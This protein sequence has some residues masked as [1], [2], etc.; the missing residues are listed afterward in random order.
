[1]LPLWL[2][3]TLRSFEEFLLSMIAISERYKGVK[4]ILVK[5]TNWVGDTIIAFPAVH[6]L[7]GLFPQ[8]H[9]SVL[10]KAY[11]AELWRAN[12]D[13]DEVIP[14]D[15]PTGAR[16]IFGELGIA[17]LIRDKTIDLAIILPR[18]FSSAWMVFLGGVPNRIGYKSGGRD[19]L[20]TEGVDCKTEL[21]SRHRM[22]YYLKLVECLGRG[23][24]LSLPSLSLNGEIDKWA[25]NFLLLNG[26]K[27]KVVIGFNPG[28]T[29]GEAK[30]WPPERF[31]ELGRRLREDYGA[32][33]LIFGSS[34]LKEKDLNATIAEGIGEGCLNL[35]GQTSLLEL[36]SLLRQCHL[37]VTNDTG[38]MHV[39]AAAGTRVVAIFGPTDPRTTSPLGEGHVIIRQ[40]VSCSPCL[41]RVC[42]E[43]HRCMD[44]IGVAKVYKT[45][46]AHLNS[47]TAS[48]KG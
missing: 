41:K 15:M 30:C 37:L 32:Y 38:T 19:W 27:G 44:L 36:T 17:R 13:I 1:M 48:V 35:S 28:A 3:N 25:N 22:Y 16:R 43:D 2:T 39:A 4:K 31:V 21:L 33:I 24:S 10:A 20:L 11:L 34:R 46:S 8:V 14:Y 12:P 9:I 47:R 26:L 40:N 29:Y 45:V 23:P 42:P 5:G 7:R 18:S 6:S